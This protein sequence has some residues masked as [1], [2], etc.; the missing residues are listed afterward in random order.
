LKIKEDHIIKFTIFAGII[1]LVTPFLLN[2]L[3]DL[4]MPGMKM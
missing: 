3:I 1:I 4:L 2:M